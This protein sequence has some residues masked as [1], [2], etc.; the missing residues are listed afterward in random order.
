M[1]D[2]I[3]GDRRSRAVISDYEDR[4]RYDKRYEEARN[5]AYEQSLRHRLPRGRMR[6]VALSNRVDIKETYEM[7][8]RKIS[9]HR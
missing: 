4:R 1:A 7:Y 3:T 2:K 6:R 8:E 5:F 9:I